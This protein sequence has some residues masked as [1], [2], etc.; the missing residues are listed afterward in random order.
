MKI[1][2]VMMGR[3]Y[4]ES[5]DL[6]EFLELPEQAS[7]DHAID[8]LRESLPP[9]ADFPGSCLVALSGK[10]VGTIASHSAVPLS[11]GD[12]LMLLAPVAGG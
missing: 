9:G 6:P 11:D 8:R 10:H 2:V 1:R 12:E 5:E 3:H 4:H 7:L